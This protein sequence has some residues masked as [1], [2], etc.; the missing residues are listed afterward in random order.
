MNWSDFQISYRRSGCDL[1]AFKPPDDDLCPDN[2]RSLGFW[3]VAR[4]LGSAR[5]APPLDNWLRFSAEVH[6]KILRRGIQAIPQLEIEEALRG[7]FFNP[8][9]LPETGIPAEIG[10]QAVDSLEGRRRAF[11]AFGCELPL[12]GPGFNPLDPG[13]PGN[14]NRL[15]ELLCELAG[16]GICAFVHTQ[17]PLDG[18][19]ATTE[20]AAQRADFVIALPNGKGLVIE[21]GDHGDPERLRDEQRDRKFAEP[22]LGFETLRPANLD[23]ATPGF[24]RTL[25]EALERIGA[26]DFLPPPGEQPAM[27]ARPF[28]AAPLIHRI[29]CCLV[30]MLLENEGFWPGPCLTIHAI[31]RDL[32][33]T[34]IALASFLLQQSKLHRLF[35]RE[36]SPPP[37]TLVVHSAGDRSL[38][39]AAEHRLLAR[40]GVEIRETVEPPGSIRADLVLDVAVAAGTLL[41]PY[42][43]PVHGSLVVVRNA[44]PHLQ[45]PF[46]PSTAEPEACD[47]SENL[48]RNL[49][50]FLRDFFRKREFR[51]GQIGI[52]RG[53]LGGRDTVG[54]LPT[55]AGKSICFQLAGLLRPG[56]TLVVSPIIAL[57]DDQVES[58]ASRHRID[59]ASAIH[60]GGPHLESA[61]LLAVLESSC[62]VYVAPERFQRQPFRD[63]LESSTLL[64]PHR[65]TLAVIDEAH[66]VSMWGHDFRPAYLRLADNIRRYCRSGAGRPPP[67]LSLTGTAS[68]LVLIDLMR[69]LR[70]NDAEN[71]VRPATFARPELRFRV[72]RTQRSLKRHLLKSQVLP[73]IAR[74]LGVENVLEQAYGMVFD[75][76]PKSIWSLV[77]DVSAGC[78]AALAHYPLDKL[79]KSVP[80]GIYT[81]KCPLNSPDGAPRTSLEENWESYKREVFRRFARGRIRCLFGNTAVSVGID[82]PR[83]R[84]I[85]NISMPQSMEDYYQQAGRAGRDGRESFCYLLFAEGQPQWNDNWFLGKGAP[86]RGSDVDNAKFFHTRNFPGQEEEEFNLETVLRTLLRAH[87]DGR[88]PVVRYDDRKLKE[89]NP[90]QSPNSKQVPGADDSQKF[91]GYLTLLGILKD[92]TLE[93]MKANTVV[94]AELDP[95]FARCLAESNW[96]AAEDHVVRSLLGYYNRYYPKREDD[97]RREIDGLRDAGTNG[98]FLT[99]ACAHLIR[100]IYDKIAYQRRNAIRD[101]TMF[102]R[103]AAAA[104]EERAAAIIRDYFD[105]SR[106][107]QELLAMRG[108][109]PDYQRVASLLAT[110]SENAEAEQLFWETSRL[111]SETERADWILIRAAAKVF[112][113][114]GGEQTTAELHQAAVTHGRGFLDGVCL[115]FARL[116]STTR[117]PAW[118]D[119][120]AALLFSCYDDSGLREACLAVV[121]APDFPEVFQAEIPALLAARQLRRLNER[122]DQHAA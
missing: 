106:F 29:E 65:V 46:L 74:R 3:L 101:I 78:Q 76:V 23:I 27:A 34:G 110:L 51:D 14:E 77:G 49:E 116:V 84:Y 63:A 93:G 56:T 86:E 25:A 66:C 70:I 91:L 87:A 120:L 102:C 100:F 59:A 7:I 118:Q 11:R 40:W 48:E 53:I 12:P 8:V 9:D 75:Y 83:L 4:P 114:R 94:A 52:L 117:M 45:L 90:E 97:L 41:A 10:W 17:V 111:L 79:W 61:R 71:I 28:L 32:P 13:Q 107:T 36:F 67:I 50:P 95:E 15:L 58:L 24:R 6:S 103:D 104:D 115:G 42:A 89:I 69:I 22:P 1:A 16:P 88:N 30:D 31:E 62:F 105:R 44:P 119:T 21:P 108:Q 37:I 121:S 81:G 26:P 122:L 18:L 96:P 73:E 60:S 72:L 20:F 35:G 47:R 38:V 68:Q 80:I 33:A 39:R 54:L 109:E 2:C 99:A 55:G 43:G 85:V 64:Q 112:L 5:A 98:K 19:F 57:M 113:G 82:N 92:Y